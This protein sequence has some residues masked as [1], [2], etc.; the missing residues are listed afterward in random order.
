MLLA[1]LALLPAQGASAWG[2]EG[3]RLI[4]EIAD[5]YLDPRAQTKVSELL[6]DD[7]LSN[8]RRSGRRTL[9][10]IANW[11][12]EIKD[13]ERGRRLAPMH[14]DDIP[15]C[16]RAGY[17]QYCRN[18]RCASAY[19][20]RQL[21]ILAAESAARSERNRALKWV[22]HLIGDIHQPLHA[23]SHDDRGGN[24][25]EVSF[26]GDRGGDGSLSL[27]ALWD[28]QLVRRW[29]RGR[30]GAN[31]IASAAIGAGD[32]AAW[33][34]GSIADWI[35]ESHEIARDFVYPRLPTAVSCSSRI[36]GVV[37]VD[38]AYYSAA[39]PIIRSRIV[40]AGVRLAR[41]LNET[42]GR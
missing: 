41:I 31:L 12:D 29:A 9:G 26:F 21:A 17:S 25:V 23:A 35:A 10:E 28:H 27:H 22:V 24:D 37:A 34:R 40:K 16:G 6:Q 13:G 4:G 8:G 19:L 36:T 32:R 18:G 15:L 33:G 20:S 3:H 2:P 30:G 11:A 5:R 14:F 42:L 1:L 7:R 38:Q 39:A